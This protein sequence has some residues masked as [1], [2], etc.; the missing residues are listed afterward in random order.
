MAARDYKKL[1][2]ERTAELAVCNDIKENSITE[3][4]KLKQRYAYLDQEFT[5]AVESNKRYQVQL[6]EQRGVISFLETKLAKMSEM[7]DDY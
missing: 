1:Y 3:H 4:A 2:N 5:N 6:H 7:L